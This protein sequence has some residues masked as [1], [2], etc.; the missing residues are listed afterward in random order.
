[1]FSVFQ[2]CSIN[3]A[4]EI[5]AK[6]HEDC[7]NMAGDTDAIMELFANIEAVCEVKDSELTLELPEPCA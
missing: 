2:V 5:A 6:M 3:L 7:V 1:M 4:P